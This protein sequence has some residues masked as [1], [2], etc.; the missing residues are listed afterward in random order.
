MGY[1]AICEG[2]DSSNTFTARTIDL[3]INFL[4]A[5]PL[6][7]LAEASAPP[8]NFICTIVNR[9]RL[10]YGCK[11]NYSYNGKPSLNSTSPPGT[12]KPDQVQLVHPQV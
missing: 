12:P 8:S 3:F 2:Q 4:I 11:A 9:I 7:V 6:P 5:N 10:K 1:V